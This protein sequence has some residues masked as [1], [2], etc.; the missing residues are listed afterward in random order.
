MR[1]RR[2]GA[3][4]ARHSWRS[5]A[6]GSIRAAR[7]AGQLANMKFSASA[8]PSAS[9]AVSTSKTNGSP[10]RAATSRRGDP[11][12]A[13][14]ERRADRGQR[15]GLPRELHEDV[16][17]GG[18]ERA[19]GADLA[20]TVAHRDPGH[21]Q[22]A[23]ARHQQRAEPDPAHE[24]R[25]AARPPASCVSTR[26]FWFCTLKSSV[27][28]RANAVAL[29]QQLARSSREVRSMAVQSPDLQQQRAVVVDVH[30]APHRRRQRHEHLLVLVDRVEPRA[31]LGAARRRSRTG[32]G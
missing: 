8:A 26:V 29:A 7:S 27:A 18:A 4:A 10:A 23:E 13:S 3:G 11:A 1:L 21:R 15:D 14:P 19:P 9:A 30:H 31:A 6:I 20:G 2:P 32:C 28:P 25:R 22:H 5:A 17:R 12:D 16:G 24:E